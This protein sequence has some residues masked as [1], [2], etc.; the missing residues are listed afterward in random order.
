M[1]FSTESFD[2]PRLEFL[3][4]S[5]RKKCT[6]RSK[7][8]KRLPVTVWVLQ[9]FLKKLNK[10][11]WFHRVVRASISAAVYG[12]LRAGEFTVKPGKDVPLLRSDVTWFADRV[13]LK[14]RVS[15]TDIFR[16]GVTVTLWKNDSSTCPFTNLKDVYDNSPVKHPQ[17]PLFQDEQGQALTYKAIVKAVKVLADE[18]G[19]NPK[20][21]SGHSFRIGGATTM[22]ILKF[23]P[24][25]IRQLGR[26]EST[27]YQ[28]YVRV[29]PMQLRQVGVAFGEARETSPT[30]MFGGLS[31][32]QAGKLQWEDLVFSKL[33]FR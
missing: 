8:N 25:V 14:L 3:L 9:K 2:N 31:D 20:S 7:T 29:S 15:K 32:V 22:G 13:E 17:A 5:I 6:H 23:P 16:Q 10:E 33:A 21:F 11:V 26:W 28:R 18:C 19:F 24:E 27:C 1:G 12:L 30:K 4:R